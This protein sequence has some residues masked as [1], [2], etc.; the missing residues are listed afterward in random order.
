MCSSDRTTDVAEGVQ[1]ERAQRH[2]TLLIVCIS[3]VC[4]AGARLLTR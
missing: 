2:G 4:L 3:S 1:P